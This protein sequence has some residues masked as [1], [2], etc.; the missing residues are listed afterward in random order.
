[1]K[2]LAIRNLSW[3][4]AQSLIAQKFSWSHINQATRALVSFI[5]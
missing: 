5:A 4:S 2:D 3:T 1:M